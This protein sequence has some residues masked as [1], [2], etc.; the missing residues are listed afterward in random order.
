M[1]R[2]LLVDDDDLFRRMLRSLLEQAGHEVAEAREGNE[3]L[4]KF[5]P[6][7]YDLMITDLIMPGKEG[8]ETIMELRNRSPE[9]RILAVS[10]GGMNFAEDYLHIARKVGAN[11]VLAKPFT[12]AQ[13][14]EAISIA[15]T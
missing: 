2:I 8:I 5:Q 6:D 13:L 4:M 1:L 15:M 11:H 12:Q 9:A 10:G 3:G 7:A 14:N